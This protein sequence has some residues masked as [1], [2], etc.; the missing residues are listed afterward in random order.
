MTS[1]IKKIS[2]IFSLILAITC[3]VSSNALAALRSVPSGYSTIQAAI[4]AA[5]A[6]DTIE[7]SPGEY[8]ESLNFASKNYTSTVTLR[9]LDRQNT[10]INPSGTSKRGLFITVS[11]NITVTN[12]TIKNGVADGTGASD[13][14]GGG[15]FVD[16]STGINVTDCNITNNSS[17]HGGGIGIRNSS[18]FLENNLIKDNI[19]QSQ[20][21]CQVSGGGIFVYS[22]SQ[23]NNQVVVSENQ[24]MNNKSQV[25]GTPPS[26]CYA[27]GAGMFHQLETVSTTHNA[28][29]NNNI[30][31]G[32]LTVGLGI[33]H[34]GGGLYIYTSQSS[35]VQVTNNTFSNNSGLDG[36]GI[37]AIESNAAI[38]NN[39]FY[40][41]IARYGGGVYGWHMS[42]NIAGNVFYKNQAS[43]AVVG[44]IGD[45]GG[46]AIL[47][48][49][50]I[51]DANHRFTNN[52][53]V[54]NTSDS[55]GGGI[56]L[57]ASSYEVSGNKIAKNTADWGGGLLVNTMPG[58]ISNPNIN[59]NIV[60]E[61]TAN[62]WGGGIGV[63]DADLRGKIINNLIAKNQAVNN[64]GGIVLYSGCLTDIIN[65]TINSN[66]KGGIRIDGSVG[67]NVLDNIITN[68]TS[69]Y[70][71]SAVGG[72][73]FI[74]TYNDVW[75]NTTNYQGVT[76]GTGSISSDPKF[77][78]TNY[79][80]LQ[81]SSP[82]VN[83]GNPNSSYFDRDGS[84]NDMGLYGG[85]NTTLTGLPYYLFP[86]NLPLVIRAFDNS[87]WAASFNS[88]GTFN[89][90]WTRI[91]GSSPTAPALA[92]IP[93][94]NSDTWLMVVL[95]AYDSLWTASFNSFGTFNNDWASIPGRA[96]D[97][98]VLAWN[99]AA[100]KLQL[101]VYA[102]DNSLWVSS[103][104]SSGTFNNDWAS[105]PGAAAN[106]P[107]LAWNAAIAKLQLLV[108][109]Y[110]SSL[111]TASFNS[112]GT[113]NNDWASIP[114]AS[115]TSPAFTGIQ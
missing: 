103:F 67:I 44:T 33:S 4:D 29:I 56:D 109:A 51:G 2:Y 70:G 66:T 115:D 8:R 55:W 79:F 21:T 69:S 7:V 43:D 57:Y 30:F 45:S 84:R 37:A 71:I 94:S 54:E 83:T 76:A 53:L 97:T 59:N 107:A 113:F 42:S 65:N 39:R 47:F 40:S 111:W 105:I 75:N 18:V 52:L 78:D 6:G 73:S 34:Y 27:L 15:I 114:G 96:V 106:T 25:P 31:S 64:G 81:T 62:D 17:A 72:S 61:N 38:L 87:L 90:N 49:E 9:G 48:D 16:G 11:K 80:H 91:S 98:P 110:D 95:D 60:V 1:N 46:G 63:G 112:S 26:S 108:R 32:N 50:S 28:S 101:V 82:C 14:W 41:N 99:P 102:S 92:W 85:P 23:S 3:W 10:I 36:G 74:P 58:T 35:Q 88:A 100:L 19:A 93:V 12:L 13:Q 77:V 104:N 24:I 22:P 89:N 5:V 86:E 68:H 20:R